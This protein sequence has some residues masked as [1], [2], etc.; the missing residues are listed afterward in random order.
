MQGVGRRRAESGPTS[1]IY[2]ICVD[3]VESSLRYTT[4]SHSTTRAQL[5]PMRSPSLRLLSA[6]LP[7]SRRAPIP[8]PRS[9]DGDW[10]SARIESTADELSVL[11][12][13]RIIVAI[14]DSIHIG[15][16]V[17]LPAT[18]ALQQSR[19]GARG[20]SGGAEPGVT[21]TQFDS[22]LSSKY[23]EVSCDYGSPRK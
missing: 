13:S 6:L 4:A 17:P 2:C 22:Y 19:N 15:G 10:K 5:A 16:F 20:S 23:P 21:G 9:V 12:P 8:G 14:R 11:I 3:L 7:S 1:Q 18:S